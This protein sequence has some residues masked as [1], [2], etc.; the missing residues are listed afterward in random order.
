MLLFQTWLTLCRILKLLF[1]HFIWLANYRNLFLMFYILC[2]SYHAESCFSRS[3]IASFLRLVKS[4]FCCFYIMCGPYVV[5]TF[6]W[7]FC[8]ACHSNIHKNFFAYPRGKGIRK[9][10]AVGSAAVGNKSV[11]LSHP[12][13]TL[14]LLLA[15][16]ENI[17]EIKLFID[18]LY[19]PD[20]KLCYC[21]SKSLSSVKN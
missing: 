15:N 10:A 18:L 4:C 20:Q 21:M 7:Y 9:P 16:L 11:S 14:L 2:G 8:I 5:E 6:F 17:K 3:Y 1:L 19:T 12:C 13:V